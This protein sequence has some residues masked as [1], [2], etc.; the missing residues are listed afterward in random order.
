M[1]SPSA[2]RGRAAFLGACPVP[3]ETLARLDSHVAL[4]DTWQRKINLVGSSTLAEVWTRHILDS[5][6]LLPAVADRRPGGLPATWLDL[7]SG[8]GFPGMVLAALGAG[9]VHLVESDGRKCAF[10]R[11]ILIATGVDAQIHPCR[12]EHLAPFHVDIV[13]ARALAPVAELL[14]LAAPFLAPSGEIWLLKGEKAEKELTRA[15][16]SWTFD[17]EFLA[18]RSDPRGVLLRLTGVRERAG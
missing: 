13:T 10:L 15:R 18:S 16:Q 7:G 8:A 1:A 5:A 9:R 3:R 2:D 17:V 12:I 14:A 4:L 6:Q 11:Q